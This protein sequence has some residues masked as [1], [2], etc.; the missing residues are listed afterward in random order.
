[1]VVNV[2]A[3]TGAL[4]VRGQNG[5]DTVNLGS[6]GIVEGLQGDVVL[7]RT[8]GSVAMNVDYHND[9]DGKNIILTTEGEFGFVRQL[10]QGEV[11]YAQSGISRLTV[12]GGDGGNT[13]SVNGTLKNALP[14]S[15]TVVH[16]GAGDDDVFVNATGGKLTVAGDNGKDDVVLSLGGQLKFIKGDVTVTNT[17]DRSTLEVLDA[18]DARARNV[19]MGVQGDFG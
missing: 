6:N 12:F 2:R 7:P 15:R 11:R 13:V 8:F 4:V 1:D 3:T 19:T 18:N 14:G 5:H 17:G 9:H 16:C 10:S